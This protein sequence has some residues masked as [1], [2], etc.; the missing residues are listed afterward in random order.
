MDHAKLAELQSPDS[1]F[2]GLSVEDWADIA[3]RAV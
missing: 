1:I 2:S 3:S